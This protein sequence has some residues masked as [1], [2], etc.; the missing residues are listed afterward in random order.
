MRK[1][2]TV[3]LKG[4]D[5]YCGRSGITKYSYLSIT[6]HTSREEQ[7]EW[8]ARLNEAIKAGTETWHDCAGEP[9]MAP[10]CSRVKSEPDDTFTVIR[11]RCCPVLGY[12]KMPKSALIRNNRTGEEGY[13]YRRGLE[14]V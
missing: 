8:R 3:K 5:P 10:L 13:V 2:N 12:H 6:R 9:H 14:L 1:G 4:L 11:S 7:T